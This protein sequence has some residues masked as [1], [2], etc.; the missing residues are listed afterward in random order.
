MQIIKKMKWFIL[1]ACLVCGLMQVVWAVEFP[2]V[3][4]KEQGP[5]NHFVPSGR[6]GDTSDLSL[7]YASKEDPFAG[8][9]CIK[10]IYT[11]NLSQGAGWAGLYWQNPPNNWGNQ[12]GGYDLS[13]AKKLTFMARGEVGDE[14]VEFKM[15]GIMG[16]CGDSDQAS[17]GPIQL[18]QEWQKYSID[19]SQLD[20]SN[21][22][23]GFC[24]AISSM[25]NPEGATFYLDEMV[26]E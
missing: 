11:A 24:F 8:S 22:I 21:V 18:T 23:G 4:Y 13:G 10:V 7:S 5:G 1:A 12:A 3:V 9:T 20:L 6:M 15:G 26:Y 25:E 16:S 17:T 19:V 2:F 14:I